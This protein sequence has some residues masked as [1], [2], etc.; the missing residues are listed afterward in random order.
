MTEGYLECVSGVFSCRGKIKRPV[1]MKLYCTEGY[2]NRYVWEM[3][4]VGEMSDEDLFGK[5]RNIDRSERRIV[6]KNATYKGR[7]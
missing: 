2:D 4:H 5:G 1:M 3:M 7:V 6:R